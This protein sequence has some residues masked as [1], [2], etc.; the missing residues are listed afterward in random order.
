MSKL[1]STSVEVIAGIFFG[2]MG[3]MFIYMSFEFFKMSK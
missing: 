1:L 3:L 2:G